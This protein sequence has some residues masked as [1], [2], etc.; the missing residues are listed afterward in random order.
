MI[1]PNATM[2]L[3]TPLIWKDGEAAPVA[4][5]DEALPEVVALVPLSCLARFWNAAKLRWLDSSELTA[6]TIPAPQWSG[7]PC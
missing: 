1:A 6:K 5:G 2:T 4:D 3:A 7:G